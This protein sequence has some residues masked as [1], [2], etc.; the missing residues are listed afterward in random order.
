L[1][2]SVLAFVA[3]VEEGGT[4]RWLA[5]SSLSLLAGWVHFLA[6]LVPVALIGSLLLIRDTG[7]VR[8]ALAS[9]AAALAGVIPLAYAG[10][11][12]GQ[13]GLAFLRGATL[14]N[15]RALPRFIGGG[16]WPLT[17]LFTVAGGITLLLWS[18]RMRRRRDRRE[19]MAIT[20]TTAWL[21]VPVLCALVLSVVKPVFSER[22]FFFELAPVTLLLASLL[23][24]VPRQLFAVGFSVCLALSALGVA[25]VYARP[26]REDWRSATALVLQ[27]ARPDDG[28]VFAP[29]YSRIPFQYYLARSALR[30]RAPISLVPANAWTNLP[31][32]DYPVAEGAL[33]DPSALIQGRRIWLVTGGASTSYS[34][35]PDARAIVDLLMRKRA[36]R[37]AKRFPGVTV[38]LYG[39]R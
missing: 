26:S 20:I 11:R 8:P 33:R 25:D 28:I 29:S 24:L 6:L 14:Q 4:A 12:A 35:A 23:R 1:V 31:L 19:L 13:G 2:F 21:V 34:D 3:A 9:F 39:D 18:T 22:Y 27:H 15:V 38:R 36:A 37:L 7:R 32:E 30:E 17:I 10:H 16:S 5:W